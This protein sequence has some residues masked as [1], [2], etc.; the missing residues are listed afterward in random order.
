MFLNSAKG[1]CG[2]VLMIGATQA[3]VSN[4]DATPLPPSAGAIRDPNVRPWPAAPGTGG[5]IVIP[6]SSIPTPGDAGKRVHTNTRVFVPNEPMKPQASLARPIV[7]PPFAGT[8][9]KRQPP[10]PAST[11]WSL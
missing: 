6:Q 1:I 2:I 7:G 8:F 3:Q 4:N 11:A 10:S 5:H 9:L